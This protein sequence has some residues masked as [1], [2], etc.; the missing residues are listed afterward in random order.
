MI[1]FSPKALDTSE[2]MAWAKAELGVEIKLF[3]SG[4]SLHGYGINPLTPEEWI[5]FMGLLLLANHPSKPTVV[6]TRWVG[7]RLLAGYAALRWSRNTSHY[8]QLPQAVQL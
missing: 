2:V 1:D 6:D 3:S 8:L 4:R 7:H 5:R